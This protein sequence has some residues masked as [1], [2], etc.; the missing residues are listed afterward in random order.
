MKVTDLVRIVPLDRSVQLAQVAALRTRL[1]QEGD[2]LTEDTRAAL[3]QLVGDYLLDGGENEAIVRGVLGSLSRPERHGA[4]F[5]LHG[6]AGTGKSHL[7][8]LL[9]LLAESPAARA[10]FAEAHPPFA[11][12]C[13]ALAKLPP[14]LVVMVDL[15]AFRGHQ[16]QLEDVVFASTEQELRRPRYATEVPLTELSHALA[17]IDRHLA[18]AH[19]ADL[20]AAVAELAPGFEN[21][22]HIRAENPAGAVRIARRVVSTVGFPLDFRQSRVE[23]LASLLEVARTHNLRGVLWLIDDLSSFLSGAGAKGMAGDW[24]FLHFVAQRAKIT[25]I[26]TV[27]ALRHSPET[28]AEAEPFATGQLE[29]QAEGSLGLSPAQVRS[30]V[31]QRV[32]RP[33]DPAGLES[34]IRELHH[35]YAARL[36]PAPFT[37]EQL[38]STYPLHPL[39]ARCVESIATRLFSDAGSL[40]AFVQAAVAGDP[41]RGLSGAGDR[42]WSDLLSPAEAYDYFEPQIAGHPDVSVYVYDVVDFFVKNAGTLAPGREP[43]CLAAAKALTLCRL[44]NLTPTVAE[45]AD[46]L[47]PAVEVPQL[48]VEEL[49]GVLEAMRL[50]GRHMEVRRQPGEGADLYRADA[51]TTF[52]DAVRRR[53]AA[54]K[55]TIDDDDR[56]LRDY[57][58]SVASDPSLPLAELGPDPVTQDIEWHNTTRSVSLQTVN[59]ASLQAGD[60]TDAAGVLAD[61]ATL[62]DCLIY[63]ADI[64][65]AGVQ[66][67]R[68]QSLAASLPPERWIAGLLAWIPRTLTDQELDTLKA[69]LGCRLLLADPGLA[70]SPEAAGLRRRLEEERSALDQETRSIA[71]NAYYEGEVLTN[72]GVVLAP[73]ELLPLRGDWQA[74]VTAMASYALGR[75]FPAFPPIA[76]ARRLE[77]AE[78]M[79]LLVEEFVRRG[80]APVDPGTPLDALIVGFAR[81]LGVAAAER[82][83]YVLRADGPAVRAVMDLVRRR[84]RSPDHEQSPPFECS[85]LALN[86]LKSELGLP[87]ELFELVIATLLR[88]G[89]LVALDEHDAALPWWRI[90]APIRRHVVRAA[91]PPLLQY[92]EW[93]EVGRLARAVLGSGVVHPDRA[94]QES[95]WEHFLTERERHARR[96]ASLKAQLQELSARLGQS[97]QRWEETRQALNALDQFFNLFDENLPAA[98][99]MKEVLSRTTPY[100]RAVGGRVYLRGL[101]EFVQEL[102]DFLQGPAKE[103]IA[104]HDYVH[105]PALVIANHTELVRVRDRL[106]AFLESGEEL[107]RDRTPL[108]RTAQAFMAAYRRTYL[109]WHASQYRAGLFEPYGAFRQSQE[110]AAL[111]RLSRI[112]LDMEVNKPTVDGMVEDQLAQRCAAPGL[113]EALN[114]RPVCARCGLRLDDELRLISVDQIREATLEALRAYL[115]RLRSPEV[116]AKVRAYADSLPDASEMRRALDQALALPPKARPREVLATF[117]E[118]LIAHLNR[119]LGGQSVH[120][121][122]LQALGTQLVDRTL[123]RGEIRRIVEN[124]LNADE[125]LDDDDLMV[126]DR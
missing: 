60:L 63:V 69:G 40:P 52:A 10:L 95:L 43:L 70:G 7:L 77:N 116:E 5:Y 85:D 108:M 65:R 34:Q 104:I 36:L 86:M 55:A 71:L 59:L 42:S 78:Q 68:W 47:F 26:W 73:G 3:T 88:T 24:A 1:E 57:L 46:A 56:R 93:H 13:E 67:Q 103:L 35:A 32:V 39:T 58:V 100:L 38:A 107:L 82:D 94:T 49:Q 14:L 44:A 20:D 25:P 122:R 90:E 101:L 9:S 8:A 21:W 50:K 31:A 84:D 76:P 126:V 83:R 99:G 97:G 125:D 15:A 45:L 66:R 110:Y 124:W 92:Q 2:H 18:P 87:G 105:D 12:L 89:Q 54:M 106:V 112:A 23:R 96:S 4:A 11:A 37:A 118:D 102:E 72:R 98:T 53:V 115:A 117:S 114:D 51:R 17:L 28:L 79:D 80:S 6:L 81:P 75:L 61:P 111:D 123:T 62:E 64:L 29:G 91:R 16:E 22:E 19:R 30:V 27:V 48:P 119:A 41:A 121:R 109:G 120:S 74:T 113:A 33:V